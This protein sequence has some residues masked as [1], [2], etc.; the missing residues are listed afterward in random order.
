MTN[1]PSPTNEKEQPIKWSNFLLWLA[2]AL[3]LR[4]QV[5]E[6]RW[7]PSGSMLPTL[8]IQDKILVEKISP[9]IA[10]LQHKD[11][12]RGSIVV[13]RPP[14]NLVNAGY[15]KSKALIKR[16]VGVP[17]DVIEVHD[18][19]LVRN[20]KVINEV[21]RAGPITYEQP[22]IKISEG[23]LWVLGDNRN[24]SLDS[25]LWGPLPAKNVVGTAIWR[26]WP[27]ENFGPI[28]FPALK[29]IEL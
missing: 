1:Q 7:I 4:W 18:G 17:G 19:N 5:V 23:Q 22:E 9:K 6:P 27:L 26:Y 11:L 2:L 3:L 13:F 14:T 24:S 20:G 8:Q 21:W 12:H 28:R 10:E 29:R 15:D 25:H 16:I